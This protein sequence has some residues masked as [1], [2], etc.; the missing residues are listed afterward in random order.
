MRRTQGIRWDKSLRV[1]QS[2]LGPL[3]I[4][5]LFAALY[6]LGCL[7]KI[8]DMILLALLPIFNCLFRFKFYFRITLALRLPNGFDEFELHFASVVSAVLTIV[9]KLLHFVF[10]VAERRFVLF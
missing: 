4:Q 10:L 7:L 1:Q 5:F 9:K 6:E 2:P 3:T 8:T